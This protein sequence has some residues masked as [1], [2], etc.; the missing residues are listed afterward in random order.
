MNIFAV[1]KKT[2]VL[3]MFAIGLLFIMN[4]SKP[5]TTPPGGTGNVLFLPWEFDITIDNYN[6]HFK[7]NGKITANYLITGVPND[8]GV[9]KLGFREIHFKGNSALDLDYVKGEPM[10][11]MVT[12]FEENI[13]LKRIRFMTIFLK[14]GGYVFTDSLNITVIDIGR[15]YEPDYVN[16]GYKNGRP[17]II[18]IPMQKVKCSYKDPL[19]GTET[20]PIEKTIKGKFIYSLQ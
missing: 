18:E 9:L 15:K 16:G 6:G 7:A 17:A 3:C 5:K 19:T 13:G 1:M 11:G 12:D 10:W 8:G 2:I 4:C 14:N 20:N